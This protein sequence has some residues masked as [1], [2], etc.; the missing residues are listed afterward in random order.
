MYW[1][2]TVR[3]CWPRSVSAISR[4]STIQDVL[5]DGENDENAIRQFSD[6]LQSRASGTA[7]FDFEG[8][9]QFLTFM[10]LMQ[11]HN[12]Y[13]VSVIP[14]S[15]VEKDGTAIIMHTMK[16]AFIITAAIVFSVAVI[17]VFFLLRNK[18]RRDY[19]RYVQNIN[20]AI[21]QNIDT[22]IFIVDGHTGQV[23]YAFENAEKIL[24]IKPQNLG[25][26]AAGVPAA[27]MRRYAVS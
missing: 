3:L 20:E 2:I 27:F 8:E 26:T 24:G 13:Y 4:Y 12:W 25:K 14:L 15:M 23:E 9:K 17:A 7:V 21:A 11:K 10:P 16:M 6:A 18:K 1:M 22:A 5:K 19:E